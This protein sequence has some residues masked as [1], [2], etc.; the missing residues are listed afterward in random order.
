MPSGSPPDQPS[1]AF[2]R[3]ATIGRYVVLGLVGRGGMGEVYA[4]YDHELDRKV[5]VKLL[6]VRPGAG[7]SLAEGRQRTL[8]EAQAIARLSHPNVVVVYDVG[9]FEDQVF[10]AMEFVDGNTVTYWLQAKTRTWQEIIDVFAAAGRGLQAAH[11]KEL[12][13]RD[14]KPDN[15]MVGRDGGV[16][17]MDFGLARQVGVGDKGDKP[18]RAPLDIARAFVE[19]ASAGNGLSTLV[20]NTAPEGSSDTQEIVNHSGLFDT[21]LTRTGAMMGTPAYMAPEQFLGTATDARTDQF[22]FSVAL[23]EALYGERPFSG[24][25]MFALTANVV[26]G[27]IKDAPANAKVPQ[28]VRKILLRGLRP[29]ARERFPS[30]KAL[31]EALGKDPAI[32]RRRRAL[33][34]A[35]MLL[36]LAVGLG[37]RQSLAGRQDV[38]CGG[39][40]A[41]LA[42]VWEL[43]GG[44]GSAE[45]ARQ[46]TIHRAFLATGKA[47]AADAFAGVKR[48]LTTYAQNW[49]GMYR[50]A[51]EATHVR[52]EQ[53]A[54][55]LDLRMACLQER[56]G[57]LRALTRVLSAANGDVVEKAV[58]ATNA[59]GSLDRCADVTLLRSVVRPPEDPAT[60]ARV[61]ALRARLADLKAGFDAG[62]VRQG[63][64]ESA[65][66]VEDAR[67]VGY[68]PLVAE[69]LAL[70]GNSRIKAFE[71]TAA[72]AAL[73]EAYWR[74]DASHDDDVRAEV[75]TQLVW[76]TGYLE[77]NRSDAAR[78]AR[79]ADAVL[80]RVGGHDLVR[81]WL[82][83]NQA[84]L[85][86]GPG[87]AEKDL[88]ALLNA[89]ALKAK[90]LGLDNPDV[91]LTEGNIAVALQNLGR[92]QEALGHAE[93]AIEIVTRGNGAEHPD[94]AVQLSNRGEILNAL[95]R[96][97]EARQ[98][99]ERARIIWEREL[100]VDNRSLGYALTGIGESY[101]S[102][103]DPAS[104]VTPLER[105]VRIRAEKET[106]VELRA[107]TTFALAR[108]LW[109]AKR[110]RVRA[111]VLAESAREGYAR[112]AVVAKRVDVDGWLSHHRPG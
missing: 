98:S 92:N 33:A 97:R 60:R 49:A 27:N 38:G 86:S 44:K 13:H 46:A 32:A 57:G 89:A 29:D 28:W 52:G 21:Q 59:L 108:A 8:R 39:A 73:E 15:V 75:A 77:G 83:N 9:T 65:S 67:R 3:G 107:D 72:V 6:R 71:G 16:R 58:S 45:S 50:D 100:G 102:E 76:A 48:V 56:L 74:A 41:R 12:V 103:G 94:L 23:Y 2:P 17:V 78:W 14:F 68:E 70:V 25:S 99:F 85:G 93:R 87:N 30:M 81:A 110:D 40:A 5:A 43:P 22:S 47:Y 109:E 91:G 24:N 51:C 34:L 82:L 53:S 111:R 11:D 104:A 18:E 4:A 1:A 63:L 37:V 31:I 62:K 101:L 106:D 42:D 19:G 79:M 112:S 10:I 55:V 69:A 88:S 54:E 61:E 35:A 64:D 80:S 26:Q 7:L 95:G 20:I 36:P 105:A 84:V 66:L 96:P 90:V